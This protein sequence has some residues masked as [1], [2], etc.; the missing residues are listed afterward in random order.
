MAAPFSH[1]HF[2]G[3][4]Y[5]NDIAGFP[6]SCSVCGKVT[7]RNPLPVV[8]AIIPV[9]ARDQLQGVLAVRRA[10]SPHVGQLALPGG[11]IN[12][13]ESWQDALIREVFEE[14]G[15]AV[16]FAEL[17]DVL[18]VRSAPDGTLL[19]FAEVEAITAAKVKKLKPTEE[20][21]EITVTN[22]PSL[23]A[24]PLHAEAVTRFLQ[25][26]EEFL[27]GLFN[28][29]LPPGVNPLPP[30]SELAQGG[31]P[32]LPFPMER[33]LASPLKSA[34]KAQ[35]SAIYQ[36]KLTLK[37]SKPPIWRRILVPS[38][39]KLSKL[40][41][42]IQILMGWDGYHLHD[43][44]IP[45]SD[46]RPQYEDSTFDEP[47]THLYEVLQDTKDK[48]QYIYDFGDYWQ[49]DITLEKVLPPNP[50]QKHPICIKGVRA[51]P[52]EDS[53]GIWGYY[54][55][56][57]VLADPNNPEYEDRLEWVGEPINPDA[58]DIDSINEQLKRVKV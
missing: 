57:E 46:F 33:M 48:L 31:I 19:L 29:L 1:C 25:P 45:N 36:L 56:L 49:V 21:S 23:M 28:S 3:A 15:H 52:L 26:P 47:R 7:Y 55:L 17:D 6:R 50:D 13:G 41:D 44:V 30:L 20:A 22:D 43:F 4:A 24:F 40:H 35:K 11:Y 58:F 5:P 2:C 8:V 16:Q 10:I 34:T 39:I 14:T 9:V 53:G 42:L 37:N 12:D 27:Q 51:A 18:F 38:K 54:N 32:M